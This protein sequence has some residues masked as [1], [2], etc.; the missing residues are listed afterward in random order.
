[1]D[2][3]ADQLANGC[4]FRM[5][6]VIDVFTREAL[7]IEVGQRLRGDD[8]VRTLD[9]IRRSRRPP[10]YLFVD[11]GSE[12]SG[13]LLDLWAYRHKV[14]IDFSRPGKPVDN[15]LAGAPASGCSR[16]YLDDSIAELR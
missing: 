15:C 8:V 5:L 12:F 10:K 7:A 4:K 13:K 9:T 14:R 11:N 2:F 6:T 1:M 16:F 3:A